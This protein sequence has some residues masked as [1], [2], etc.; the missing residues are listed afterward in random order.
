MPARLV[1]RPRREG[2]ILAGH[3]WVYRAD[4]ARLEGAWRADEAVSVVDA[5]G[6]LVGRGFYNPRPQIVCR[7]LTR[8]DEPVHAARSPA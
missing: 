8:D 5:G 4:V 2:R 6:H 7:L 1:L 3:P